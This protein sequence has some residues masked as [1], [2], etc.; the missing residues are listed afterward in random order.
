MAK[1][2]RR[3]LAAAVFLVVLAAYTSTAGRPG[4][5]PGTAGAPAGSG[6]R[7]RAA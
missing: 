7:R 6:R 5:G 4:P 1:G 2:R 3:L